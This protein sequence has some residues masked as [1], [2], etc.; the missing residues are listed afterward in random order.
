MKTNIYKDIFLV[1]SFLCIATF[2]QAQ[3]NSKENF[4]RKNKL[5]VEDSTKFFNYLY[6]S[7]AY[8]LFSP[9]KDL[10]YDSALMIVPTSAFLWQQRA[11]AYFKQMKYEKGAAFLDSAVKY[12]RNEYLEY[13]AFMK[14]IFRK[15]YKESIADFTMVLKERGELFVMDHPCS[16]YMSLCYLQLNEFDSAKVYLNQAINF[17]Q[18]KFH[19]TSLNC[20]DNFYMG[21]ILFEQER[22][23]EAIAEF[24]KALVTYSKFSDAQ[25]YKALCIEKKGQKKEASK[26]AITA[27]LENFKAGYTINE[28]N[29]I[30][31]CY[32]YQLRLAFVES[33]ANR[34]KEK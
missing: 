31:E 17:E 28:G 29:S 32:P 4:S 16:F 27:A 23:D 3:N 21:I 25:L 34:L 9:K 30:Y 1:L 8:S 14:C 7:E 2:T 20:L 5:S 11:M 10:Y 33:I 26:L 24:D 19:S 15:N 13:R 6:K 18:K 12:K 22:N